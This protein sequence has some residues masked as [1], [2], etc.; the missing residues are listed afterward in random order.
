M[1]RMLISVPRYILKLTVI[2]CVPSASPARALLLH[3]TVLCCK[4]IRKDIRNDTHNM[5]DTNISIAQSS[6]TT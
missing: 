2:T 3:V 5:R 6:Q 1:A 4:D